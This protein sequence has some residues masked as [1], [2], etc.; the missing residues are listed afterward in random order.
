MASSGDNV[1]FERR[2]LTVI[3]ARTGR[4]GAWN[5]MPPRSPRFKAL[6]P[7]MEKSNLAFGGLKNFRHRFDKAIAEA[8]I[9]DF[10]W[11]I[12]ATLRQ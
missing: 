8:G 7:N 6:L 2:L 10:D 5:R 9:R 12:C 4:R 3:L 11:P 1:N